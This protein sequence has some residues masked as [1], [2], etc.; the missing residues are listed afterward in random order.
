MFEQTFIT[1]AQGSK[2]LWTT[3]AGVTGQFA[4]VAAMILAP[5]V[6]PEALPRMQSFVNIV[7]PPGPPPP[8]PAQ[9]APQPTRTASVKPFID[10]SGHVLQPSTVPTRIEMVV[11]EP[12]APG[13]AYVPGGIPNGTLGGVANGIVGGILMAGAAAIAPPRPVETAKPMENTP[14][15][16]API[17]TKLGGV[18]LAGKLISQ[19]DPVY[20]EIARRMRV[21]GVVELMAVVGTDGRIRELKLISGNPLLTQ[22]AL[23]AVRRWVYRPTY[24]NGDPVEVMAPVTVSFKLN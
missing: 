18:V 16:A 2:R 21:Q 15:P 20:P 19:I 12:P 5:M 3:C 17:R 11:D 9:S 13:G 6:F 23:D 1:E 8:P 10:P 14:A 22:A 4:L 7:A 24:L